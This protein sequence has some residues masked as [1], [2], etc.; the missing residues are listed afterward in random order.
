MI[1]RSQTCRKELI[2][3][4]CKTWLTEHILFSTSI[5]RIVELFGCLTTSYRHL[6]NQPFIRFAQCHDIIDS[7]LLQPHNI[8]GAWMSREQNMLMN[9]KKSAQ[10]EQSKLKLSTNREIETSTLQGKWSQPSTHRSKISKTL[11]ETK[12]EQIHTR[13]KLYEEILSIMQ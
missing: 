10:L 13:Q 5:G 11:N 3:K 9:Q 1:C 6:A 8:A 12:L 4:S 7:K 2:N